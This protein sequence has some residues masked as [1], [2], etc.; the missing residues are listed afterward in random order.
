MCIR[1][2]SMAGPLVTRKLTP[3][4]LAIIVESVVLPSPG[5]PWRRTWSRGSFL[6]REDFIKISSFSFALSWPI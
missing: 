2:S 3:S 5:G 1:D 6:E 4:S